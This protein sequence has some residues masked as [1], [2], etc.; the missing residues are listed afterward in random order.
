MY[1]KEVIEFQ[2]LIG[3]DIGTSLDIPTAPFVDREKAESP[4]RI[5]DIP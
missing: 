2:E 1:N 3:T 4:T 5:N